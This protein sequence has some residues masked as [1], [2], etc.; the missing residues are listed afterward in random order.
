MPLVKAYL[1]A[2]LSPSL[3]Y[4]LGNVHGL[5]VTHVSLVECDSKNSHKVYTKILF[6]VVNSLNLN[7]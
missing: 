3:V 2:A 5:V 4:Q 7:E 6:P 1:S